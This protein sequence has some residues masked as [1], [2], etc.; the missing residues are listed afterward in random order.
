VAELLDREVA[1]GDE[2]GQLRMLENLRFDPREELN[3]PSLAAELASEADLYVNDAFGAA[4]RAHASVHGIVKFMPSAAAG[5]LMETELEYLGRVLNNPGR[6]L[7]AI[8]GGRY[9][10]GDFG[11]LQEA[12]RGRVKAVMAIGEAQGR[13][14][15]ALS[16]VVP[17]TPCESLAQAVARAFA[18]ASPGDVVLLA[19]ACSSFD[20]FRDYAER[21]RA[22][23]GEVRKLAAAAHPDPGGPRG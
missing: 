15:D 14:Q 19:P 11:R 4:H 7:V 1:F 23:K 22:F 18:V 8:L 17:V 21:G 5:L 2:Q 20:M 13:V 12:A 9:K 10:G 16:P 3:D 6:P